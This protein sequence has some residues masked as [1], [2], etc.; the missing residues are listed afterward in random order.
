MTLSLLPSDSRL[1]VT[2]TQQVLF[3]ELEGDVVAIEADA[4]NLTGDGSNVTV[5]EVRYLHHYDTAVCF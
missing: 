2:G 5:Q 3:L 1:G 4:S